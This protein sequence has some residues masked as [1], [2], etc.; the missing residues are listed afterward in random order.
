MKLI[1]NFFSF[2]LFISLCADQ[3]FRALLHPSGKYLFFMLFSFHLN[4]LLA[5]IRAFFFLVLFFYAVRL[6][7]FRREYVLRAECPLA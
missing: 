5:L 2:Q 6:K 3:G 7:L 1:S 4:Y